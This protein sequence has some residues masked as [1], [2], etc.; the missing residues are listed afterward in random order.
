MGVFNTADALGGWED[1]WK[2]LR[3]SST[4]AGCLEERGQPTPVS[5]QKRDRT[6]NKPIVSKSLLKYYVKAFRALEDLN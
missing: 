6:K 1:E 5:C 4:Q 3:V 2:R